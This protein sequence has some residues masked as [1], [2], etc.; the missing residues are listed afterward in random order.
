MCASNFV[1]GFSG[2]SAPGFEGGLSILGDEASVGLRALRT[3]VGSKNAAATSATSAATLR[4]HWSG[5]S[6]AGEAR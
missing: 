3:C 4:A 5:A 2:G 6:W 1:L